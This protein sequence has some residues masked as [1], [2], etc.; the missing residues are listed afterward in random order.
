MQRKPETQPAPEEPMGD[1]YSGPP[2]DDE[3]FEDKPP[4]DDE[5]EAPPRDQKPPQDVR[6]SP[7][8]P[9]QPLYGVVPDFD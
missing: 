2:I 5:P 7:E 6:E 3:E 1:I 8:D 9:T 4:K